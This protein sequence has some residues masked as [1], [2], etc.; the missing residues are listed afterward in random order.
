M[1]IQGNKQYN[2]YGA[3]LGQEG[4]EEVL[5]TLEEQLA[6][7]GG[8]KNLE[9]IVFLQ[10]GE[11]PSKTKAFQ[12]KDLKWYLTIIKKPVLILAGLEIITY[13]LTLIPW[14]ALVMKEIMSPL[15]VLIDLFV[16]GWLIFEVRVGKDEEARQALTTVFLAGFGLGLLMAIFK[17]I[18]FR[19]FWAIFNLF[20]EPVYMGIV[21]FGVGLIAVL[22]IKKK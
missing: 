14:L 13:I 22:F 17:M 8:K 10:K 4:L 1:E 19:E 12:F 3:K 20:I 16:F 9:K 2:N 6:P 11:L 18:W 5:G 7:A 21:A 15:I